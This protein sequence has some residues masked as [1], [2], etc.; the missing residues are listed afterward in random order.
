MS[1]PLRKEESGM[2]S[3]IGHRGSWIVG[4]ALLV[5]GLLGLGCAATQTGALPADLARAR[6]EAAPGAS[7]FANACA[8][9][10]GQRG[11]GL[12]SAPAILGPTALPEYPRSAGSSGDPT[13]IDPQQLQIQAQSRPA[14]APS[15]D[16]FR[17]A[18]DVY[19]FIST[20]MP[21]TRPG[22]LPPGDYWAVVN[23][24]FAAQGATLP[25][26]GIGPTNASSIPIPRR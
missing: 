1:A 11:E 6:A 20:Y 8:Q 15:R 18:Q 25:A 14:G 22:Q 5:G 23:F 13:L 4:G 2:S 7:T 19:A 3:R 16:T 10:H 12:A 24:L 26:G 9:C 21:K 17:K